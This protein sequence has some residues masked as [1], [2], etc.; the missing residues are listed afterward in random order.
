MQFGFQRLRSPTSQ[1]LGNIWIG[2]SL[3][4]NSSYLLMF[5]KPPQNLVAYNNNLLFS[6]IILQADGTHLG[7]FISWG[8]SDSYSQMVGGSGIRRWFS[9][10]GHQLAVSAGWVGPEAQLGL[11]PKT[12]E[13]GLSTWSFSSQ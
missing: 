13:C 3:Q 4:E 6:L 5:N 7:A 1:I 12:P 9:W 10:A 8:F 11:S 2:C